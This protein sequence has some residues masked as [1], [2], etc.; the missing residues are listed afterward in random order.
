MATKMA[1][2]LYS[3][4]IYYVKKHWNFS[5]NDFNMIELEKRLLSMTYDN[6]K[7]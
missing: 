7:F 3:S 2:F 1:K 5:E 6:F 4:L